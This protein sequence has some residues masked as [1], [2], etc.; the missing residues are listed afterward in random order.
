MRNILLAFIPIFLGAQ[1]IP[2]P[3]YPQP[4]FQRADWRS[5]NGEW[6]FEFDDNNMGAGERWQNPA[7]KFTRKITVPYAFESKLSGI[8][9]TS[10][11]PHVWYKRE[12][13]IPAEWR[14]RHVLLHFGAVD[15][16][17]QVWLNG[18]FLGMHEGGN[19][20]FHFDITQHLNPTGA[21]TLAVQA[22]D[23]PTDRYIPRGKQYWLPKSRGIFYTRT[24]GIW[25][26]VWMEATGTNYIKRVKVEAGMDGIAKFSA[27][28]A[29]PVAGLH[30]TGSLSREGV[31]AGRF[32]AVTTSLGTVE[33]A[34]AVRDP[35]L[36]SPDNPALYDITYRLQSQDT[37]L[38]QVQSYLGFRQVAI[39][40]GQF[41]LNRRPMLFRSVLDQGY[42]AEGIL[43]PPTDEALKFDIRMMKDMGFNSVRKH[44]KLEDPR[45]LYWADKMGLMVSS[46]MANAYLYDEEYAARFTREWIEAMERDTSHPSIVMWIP[47]NESWGVSDLSDSRQQNHLKAM[48]TLTKSLDATRPVI[49][50]D[51]WEHT[52]MTDLMGLH[53]YAR[54]GEQ[55][56]AKYAHLRME[57]GLAIPAN[58]RAALA[59]GFQYNGAPFFL[60]EFGGVAWVMP[61]TKAAEDAWG[62]A[63][64]E[65]SEEATI[66]R[67]LGLFRA[68][69]RFPS[70]IGYCYTQLTDV[71]QEINGL[72]TYDRKLKFPLAR[73]KEMN[74]FPRR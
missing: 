54:T 44:Q 5:L 33:A 15:Y 60:S 68:A 7:R 31:E 19:T 59:P 63:G 55:L 16:R 41:L 30:L 11:H 9:D 32:T 42:W 49:D 58:G 28:L 39:E 40:H 51:G 67:M 38:D 17:A 25:Q 71:E 26:P 74:S 46:E 52:D 37:T 64:L 21:N 50:N 66:E 23:P 47:V 70:S 57:K 12:V 29:H 35:I 27:R 8:G 62:Y 72:L 36:W 48:Y 61:G 6:A 56:E 45:F 22:W 4:Q 2:R 34:I 53:D 14:G 24:S 13:A 43:T 1:S 73:I 3:E 20:P 10:F 18:Q 69:A 65:K